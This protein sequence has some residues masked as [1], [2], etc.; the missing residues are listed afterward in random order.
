M[1][2]SREQHVESVPTGA[3]QGDPTEANQGLP[4]AHAI[5]LTLYDLPF[6]DEGAWWRT[7]QYGNLPFLEITYTST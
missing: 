4:C 2:N 1:P 5:H 6:I 7:F 3:G